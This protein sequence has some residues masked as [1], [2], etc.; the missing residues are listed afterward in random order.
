MPNFGL[1]VTPTFNPMSYEQYV[2]PFKDYAEIYNK[3]SDAY[4][5][6]EM[7]A[8]KWEKLANSS[9][10]T[11]Q[12]Q[13]YKKYA[14]DL[15]LAASDLAENGLNHKTRS[16]LS[17]LRNRYTK[18]IQPISDAYTLREEERKMQRHAK[19]QHPDIMF[20]RDATNTGLSAYMAGIPELQTYNGEMLTKYTAAAAKNLANEVRENLIKD[21]KKSGWYHILGD[22]YYEKALRTG[23]TADE[24]ISTLYDSE[25]GEIKEGANP[26]LRKILDTA[27]IQSGMTDWSNWEELKDRAYTYAGMGLWES[28][29]KVDY[30]HLA[31][32][33]YKSGDNNEIIYNPINPVA[34]YTQRQRNEDEK[35]INEFESKGYISTSGK[36]TKK[37]IDEIL[38][39]IH[40]PNPVTS[41]G[42]GGA[43]RITTEQNESDSDLFNIVYRWAQKDKPDISKEQFRNA[44]QNNPDYVVALYNRMKE[45]NPFSKYDANKSYEYNYH[46]DSS[47]QS[48]F[49]NLVRGDLYEVDFD[50]ESNSWKDTG[51]KL[52]HKDFI[53]TNYTVTDINF[54]M[55]GNTI[56][57]N[58]PDG[59]KEYRM[60]TNINPTAETSRDN[61]VKAAYLYGAALNEG[62]ALVY[63]NTS[64][65]YVLSNKPL[66]PAE[67]MQYQAEKANWELKAYQYNSQIGFTNK[68]KT[69]EYKP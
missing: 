33:D 5:A 10:D 36:L 32:P 49:K 48:N 68:S 52:S 42:T 31:D 6:L 19:L 16:T 15:R 35:A 64:G 66:T 26:Y 67:I 58:T 54:G 2:Q 23:L 17:N 1:V 9:I 57:V 45:D 53:S 50:S 8:N 30:K 55:Y 20:N 13:Q 37:A 12:Y 22:K 34:I 38:K 21:G 62:K 47:E 65:R 4:D 61:A 18:E 59:I 3:I 46:L 25:T 41:G 43:S 27:I 7:E 24:V 69:V 11:V 56:L 63:D 40:N 14:D 39:P 60:P 44:V 29:G 51:N 28:I